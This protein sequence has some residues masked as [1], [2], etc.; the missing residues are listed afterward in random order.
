MP[1]VSSS[2]MH[3]VEY[4]ES[5]RR[6]DIWFT[7]SGL[8]SY[9]GVPLSLYLGLMGSASKGRYFNDNVRDQYA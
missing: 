5:S 6:L 9:Y 7:A 1:T 2:A 3:R 4:D 8:Y